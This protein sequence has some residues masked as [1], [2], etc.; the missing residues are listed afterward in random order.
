MQSQRTSTRFVITAAWTLVVLVSG[1][2]LASP[3]ARAQP[4][5]PS[6]VVQAELEAVARR[7]LPSALAR[8]LRTL[9]S[10][11]ALG[12]GVQRRLLTRI[13][14]QRRAP[15]LIAPATIAQARFAPPQSWAGASQAIGLVTRWLVLAP[16]AATP[17]DP[18]LA[19]RELAGLE[20][21][22][23]G[24]QEEGVHG[25]VRWI[26]RA[27]HGP[28]GGVSLEGLLPHDAPAAAHLAAIVEA[29]RDMDVVLSVGTSGSLVASVHGLDS[30]LVLGPHTGA[31]PAAVD[32]A[33]APVRLRA[34]RNLLTLTLLRGKGRA[35]VFARFTDP[36]GL[37]VPGLAFGLPDGSLP[38]ILAAAPLRA[39]ADAVEQPG[40]RRSAPEALR[41]LAAR[42]ALGLGEPPS[43]GQ[44]SLDERLVAS[45]SS[46]PASELLLALPHLRREESRVAALQ[47]ALAGRSASGAREQGLL[48]LQLAA[49]VAEKGQTMR[50]REL[51]A[52]AEA[53]RGGALPAALGQSEPF[54]LASA[55]VD[56]LDGEPALAW[57]RL[58][59]RAL[60]LDSSV[61]GASIAWTQEAAQAA[62]NL[63][64]REAA[65]KLWGRLA[66]ALPGDVEVRA[67]HA[68]A[69]VGVGHLEAGLAELGVLVRLRPDLSGYTLEAARLLSDLGRTQQ[70]RARVAEATAEAAY[71]AATL[72]ESG[73]LLEELGATDAALAAY[74]SAARLRPGDPELRAGL[75]R[76]SGGGAVKSP[77]H[78]E[79]S[80]EL[81]AT[82]IRKPRAPF[83]VL[84][85]EVHIEVN[86]DGGHTRWEQRWLR[87]QNVPDDRD[88]R[89]TFV[90]FDPTLEAVRGVDAR[91][92]RDGLAIPVLGR[93]LSQI[94]E[95]WYGLYYDLRELAIPFDDLREGDVVR[96]AYRVEP[97]GA[98]LI[99]GR[100]NT[101]EILQDRIP[102]HRGTVTVT[103]P[104]SLGLRTQ[105][106]LPDHV[107]LA[108]GRVEASRRDLAEGREEVRIELYDLPG[109]ALERMMP[110]TAE[111]AATW[112]VANYAS[113]AELAK[114]YDALIA[115]QRVLNDAMR[116][117]VETQRDAVR[118]KDG[119]ISQPRLVRRIVEGVVRDVRYVGLEFGIHGYKP[120]R[121]DQVWS[122]RF[123]DCKDQATLL[124]T[125]LEHAGVP[126]RVVLV[127]TRPEGRVPNPIPSLA[128]FDHAIVYLPDQGAYVDPTVRTFGLG[129]LPP[130]DQGAQVLVLDDQAQALG[131]AP[132]DAVGAS[133]IDGMYTLILGTDGGAGVRG[134]VVFY[135]SQAPPY[136]E[137]LA[138]EDVR[139]DRLEKMLNGRY[140]GLAL[141]AYETSDP[142]DLGR[143]FEM[144]FTAHVPQ[145]L[146]R[147]GQTLQ[148]RHPAGGAGLA[149]R[150]VGDAKRRHP[151]VLGPPARHRTRFKYVLPPGWEVRELPPSDS[152][153]TRLGQFEVSWT[154]EPG[155][156]R[157]DTVLE[158]AVDQVPVDAYGAFRV[159]ME[160]FDAVT[161]VP[162]VLVPPALVPAVGGALEVE[163]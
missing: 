19:H 126:A 20:P 111:V 24:G 64:Q 156:V 163:P 152:L 12:P 143:P 147:S 105:V 35:V 123:G 29:P 72:H 18:M 157:V 100:F 37:P 67:Q 142:R 93:E 140:P 4:L 52:L 90:R 106:S 30:R 42:R 71:D 63:G 77:F 80:P 51:L 94:S 39:F 144:G 103:A 62:T 36:E 2:R 134:K 108:G 41:L 46:L 44:G 59:E 57:R 118:G 1:S 16:R 86:A 3:A 121:S 128:L 78:Q 45:A 155:A 5:L 89:T 14:D 130:G 124:V 66:A 87:A 113:W 151:L 75:E 141:S 117:W 76:L 107:R 132:I 17:S 79:W 101:V 139:Q 8:L 153:K 102:K 148:V 154:R 9:P 15:W 115:P 150:W 48:M 145:H 133:G 31:G 6:H 81:A 136:R 99:P 149:E 98:P 158:I 83:E 55:R 96:V 161:R 74:R 10:I 95:A 40:R 22:R 25:P 47:A 54:A 129:E 85:E 68:Q 32:Q 104:K 61:A 27:D 135:G 73:R 137:R 84:S 92:Y 91:I 131:A 88:A 43:A 50:A 159:F 49:L 34:G 11:D 13:V 120:Y 82:P 162:L 146:A 110:G 69:L 7:P 125:L 138:D 70:A 127:R 33:R 109:L 122:R 60:A 53:G 38:V 116:A 160:R 97:V 114:T 56:R 119:A 58:R 26:E 65:S 21:P 23:L 112:Q 28:M